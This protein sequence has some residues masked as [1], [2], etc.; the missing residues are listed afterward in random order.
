M[1]KMNDKVLLLELVRS[2]PEWTPATDRP[3]ATSETASTTT[4]NPPA[5]RGRGRPRKSPEDSDSAESPKA[6]SE[7]R[8]GRRLLKILDGMADEIRLYWDNL[9]EAYISFADGPLEHLGKNS[10][11]EQRLA[12]LY[13]K[14]TDETLGKDGFNNAVVVLAAQAKQTGMEIELFT[15][16]GEYDGRYYYDLKNRRALSMGPDGWEIDTDAPV[17]FR[18]FSTQQPHPDPV[19]GGD[20]WRFFEH[21]NV[22]EENRLLLMVWIIGSFVP[23]IPY[24]ALLVSGSQGAGKSFFCK[25][26]KRIIDPSATELQEM[27][28]KDDDFDLLLYKH[29]CLAL[30]NIS[31]VN[32]ARADR[33]CSAITAA[34]IEK[35]QLHTDMDTIVLPCN[36]RVILNGINALT[37]RPDLLDR[38]ITIHLERIKPT[39]RRLEEE[40]NAAF[41]ADL[42]GI[43]GGIADVLSRAMEIKPT[44]SLASY[45]RMADFA[46]WGYAVAEALGGR[47]D[48]FLRAY[49]GNSAKLGDSLLENDSLMSGLVQLMGGMEQGEVAGTFKELIDRLAAIV[50]PDRNDYS[51]PTS[52]T[53]RRRLERL[54]P[55]LEEFGIRFEFG[56]HTNKGHTA[57]IIKG[58][59]PP[60]W[61]ATAAGTQPSGWTVEKPTAAVADEIVFDEEELPE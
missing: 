58:E 23:R 13:Y 36:P 3:S 38:S 29:H 20:P 27:P 14:T 37:N 25:L 9:G 17:F 53:F 30:D 10:S 5:K 40:I 42:P 34:Y 44:V 55:N 21:V 51:F 46:R 4:S 43:L 50:Q 19:T 12:L 2:A 49:G 11:L 22:T 24:P 57:R 32:A 28:K 48:E 15:R 1:D 7:G 41:D 39:G 59:P 18:N 8:G 61:A 31:S 60:S 16:V 47:G 33:L 52:H 6:A 35:R 56:K 54:R 45:P 26:L